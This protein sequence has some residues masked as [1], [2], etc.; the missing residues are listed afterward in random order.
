MMSLNNM[1]LS[2]GANS[3]IEVVNLANNYTPTILDTDVGSH[4]S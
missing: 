4:G 1:K 3:Q 2:S